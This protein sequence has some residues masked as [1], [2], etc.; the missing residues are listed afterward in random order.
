MKS[1]DTEKERRRGGS[2]VDGR[3]ECERDRD[4]PGM[5]ITTT[6]R[7][8]Y[9]RRGLGVACEDLRCRGTTVRGLRR[10]R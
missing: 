4:S 2:R 5:L 1:M 3:A 8:G 7:V 9:S 6:K 10:R